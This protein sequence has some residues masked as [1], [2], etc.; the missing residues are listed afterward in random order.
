M[1]AWKRNFWDVKRGTNTNV[2]K[3]VIIITSSMTSKKEQ[4][5]IMWSLHSTWTYR[6]RTK[7]P[8]RS[9]STTQYIFKKT[10]GCSELGLLVF[11]VCVCTLAQH[12]LILAAGYERNLESFKTIHPW[13]PHVTPSY[14]ELPGHV[15]SLGIRILDFFL[16]FKG[17]IFF[18]CDDKT[19]PTEFTIVHYFLVYISVALSTFLV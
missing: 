10:W 8:E 15:C 13:S 19:S 14:S 2:S 7:R 3:S 18:Y 9:R 16:K 12:F 17:F 11:L 5:A 6:T 4:M 1:R